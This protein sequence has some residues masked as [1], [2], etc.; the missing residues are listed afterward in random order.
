MWWEAHREGKR[1]ADILSPDRAIVLSGIFFAGD[2]FFWHLA[3]LNTTIANATLLAT[4]APVWVALFAGAFIG[5]KVTKMVGYGLILCCF[6]AFMLIGDSYALVPERLIGDVY[7]V[8]TSVFFGL[9]FLAIRVARR[10]H[11]AGALTFMS[12]TITALILLIIT[13]ISGQEMLPQSTVGILALLALGLISHTWGQGLLTVALGVLSAPFSSLVI[14]IE[15]LAAA[16]LGWLIFNEAL[17]VI[18]ILG[19]LFILGGIWIA[20]PR[21]KEEGA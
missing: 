14:F 3:I 8:A 1:L 2:L 19:G 11:S 20:R 9:Y 21:T 5:E 6:G 12:T 17:S 13:L 18:Q 10:K 15:A 16:A 4:L 7:G